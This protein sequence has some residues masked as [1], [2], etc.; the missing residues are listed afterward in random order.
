MKTKLAIMIFLAASLSASVRADDWSP[1][2]DSMMTKWGEAVQADAAWQEYPRPQLVRKK[3]VNL[4][5]LWNYS[6][7]SESADQPSSWDGKILV[8][9]ALESPLSGVGQRLSADEALWYRRTFEL[10]ELPQDRLILHFEAVDY[11]SEVWVNGRIV[12]SHVG[13]NL[14][15]SFD[16]T[17]HVQRGENEI[18]LKVVDATDAPGKYQL[19]GKQRANNSGIWYT[20]VSGIWQTVWLEEVPKTFIQS[21]K[22]TPSL[23]PNQIVLQTNVSGLPADGTKIKAKLTSADGQATAEY[24]GDYDKPLTCQTADGFALWSPASPV[25]HKLQVQVLQADRV[26]DSVDNY[27]ALREVGMFRDDAG[28]LRFTLNGKTIFHWGTLDQGWWP[29]GLLTPP[30]DAGMVFEIDFLKRAGFNMIRK[31]IK[32]EPRRYY[33]H[34]DRLGMLVWQDQVSGGSENGKE[35]PKWRRLDPNHPANSRPRAA[36]ENDPL[37]AEWPDEAHTQFMTELK[38]MVDHLYNH[39]SIVVWVPFNE[40]WG[41]HRTMK[42][43]TWIKDYDPTRHINIASGGNFF[44]VGDIADEHEYPNPHFGVAETQFAD[45]VKVCGEFGGH[46]WPVKDHQWSTAKRN[47]GYGGL[48]KSKDEFMGRYEKSLHLLGELKKQ[49][50][51]GGIYTQTTD[52]EGE[53]NG[54]MTYDRKVIKISAEQLHAIQAAALSP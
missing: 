42:I 36:T 10:D 40:R 33:Y 19:R 25:L 18:V 11:R 47:W 21:L 31:H 1:V 7:R 43:G 51:A 53:I 17:S 4:N 54:L 45:Y 24:A 29:D 3:W 41:Q 30:A 34:C 38:G 46:G 23:G 39:P 50:V 28:H 27:F 13:G 6:V 16:I 2:K 15:F 48:P 14:P 44:P 37:D 32:V 52:V 12:G 8:P 20:P 22:I 35:W 26:I 49:G 5:G 9:F